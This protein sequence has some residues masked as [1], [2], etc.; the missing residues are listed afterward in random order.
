MFD[1]VG[2][3][4][5]LVTGSAD[6]VPGFVSNPAEHLLYFDRLPAGGRMAAVVRG[7]THAFVSGEEPGH[8]QVSALVADFLAAEVMGDTR[9]R[10]RLIAAQSTALVEI[11]RR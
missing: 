3:P 2:V 7:A 4:T 10:R 5:L 9:A 6:V 1:R 8:D 11:R